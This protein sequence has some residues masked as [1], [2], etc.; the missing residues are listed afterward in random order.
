MAIYWPLLAIKRL[1]MLITWPLM[2]S[3]CDQW[4]LVVITWL[5]IAANA[6]DGHQ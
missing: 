4:A 6:I 5:L 3:D 2:A 1:L